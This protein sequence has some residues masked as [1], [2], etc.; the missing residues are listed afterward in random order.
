MEAKEII[1][2]LGFDPAKITDLDTFKKEFEPEAGKPVFIRADKVKESH[3]FP[4]LTGEILGSTLT[5]VKSTAKKYAV[6]LTADDLKDK[7][8]DD[9]IGL[10][11]EKQ[12]VLNKTIVDELTAKAG[13]GNDEKVKAWEE[14]YQKV[15]AKLNDT[16]SLLEKT[17]AEYTGFKDQAANQLKSFKLNSLKDDVFK[18]LKFRQNITPLERTGFNATIAEKY[19]FDLDETE[20]FFV[21]D[22]RTGSR[23]PSAKVTGKHKTAEEILEEEL[24]SL[25]LNEKTP[26]GGQRVGFTGFQ[27]QENPGTPPPLPKTGNRL[28][29]SRAQA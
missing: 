9:I 21:K 1:E 15:E 11:F 28:H 3:I 17:A 20:N 16:K 12:A 4:S 19:D 23:I 25:G 24:I 2:Y 10:V 18:K 26:A 6:D 7:K 5:K 27:S 13:Q 8:L 22:K 14:K 29:P